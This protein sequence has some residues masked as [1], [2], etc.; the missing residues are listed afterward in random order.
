MGSFT[1]NRHMLGS[2]SLDITSYT[3]ERI[4]G[5]LDAG[6][7]FLCDHK[8]N[9]LPKA[10]GTL[11]FA[12]ERLDRHIGYDIGEASLGSHAA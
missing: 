7:L 2:E 5:S 9:A 12:K 10:Y 8:A 6:V 3:V 1:V 4:E 11:G